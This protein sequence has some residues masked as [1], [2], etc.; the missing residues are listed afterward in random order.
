M[1]VT[2]VGP[3]R[4]RVWAAYPKA[5]VGLLRVPTYLLLLLYYGLGFV[6]AFG[7][8]K[9][10]MVWSV[11]GAGRL[12]AGALAI[13]AWYINATALN[14]LSD[15]EIDQINLSDAS[16]RPLV[17]GALRRPDL[18]IIAGTTAVLSL[19]A[20]AVLGWWT[21]GLVAIL[22]AFNTAYS[23]PPMSLSRRGG[24]AL[25]LL[26]IGYVILPMMLGLAATAQGLVA[27]AGPLVAIC[28]A[29]FV[30]RI[31]L[32]DYRDVVGDAQ[33]GKRTF[34][35]RHGSAVVVRL[36]LLGQIV[37]GVGGVIWLYGS[38]PLM[39]AG[40]IFL[41]TIGSVYLQ[42]LGR[43]AAWPKQRL[44]ISAYGRLATGQVVILLLDALARAQLAG[45]SI[46]QAVLLAVVVV[47]FC[48]SAQQ[49]IR[50]H[51]IGG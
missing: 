28:Y 33:F 49:I 22:L 5:I 47:A 4:Q 3:G 36:A 17:A 2:A 8:V 50:R 46:R 23:L 45:G 14:D 19:A 20:A 6:A 29:Q 21:A 37:A 10:G 15:Y 32:K 24:W 13:A 26:P 40:Y 16:D 41:A 42:R 11:G 43:A 25:A 1:S 44:W 27:L 31:S 38:S 9:G 48:W 12:L 30:A 34:L 18:L 51:Q 39:A 35:L 7:L